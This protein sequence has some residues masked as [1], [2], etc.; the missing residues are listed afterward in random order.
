MGELKGI[1]SG[2]VVNGSVCRDANGRRPPLGHRYLTTPHG[3]AGNGLGALVELQ[4]LSICM[5]TAGLRATVLPHA[6]A[7]ATLPSRA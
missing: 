2:L 3:R 5:T 4:A 7:G 6:K 1:Y